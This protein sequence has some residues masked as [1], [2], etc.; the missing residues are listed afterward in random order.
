MKAKLGSNPS[1]IWRSILV[2]RFIIQ[3]RVR[4]KVGNGQS[5]DIWNDDWGPQQL[6]KRSGSRDIARVDE[7]IDTNRGHWNLPVLNEVFT[8]NGVDAICAI[9]LPNVAT[10]DS[11]V[12]K[13]TPSGHLSVRS[14]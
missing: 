3:H 12:W 9:N 11:M 6:Q 14:A 10:H 7:L 5:I 4:W 2:A 13:H 8:R 1:F